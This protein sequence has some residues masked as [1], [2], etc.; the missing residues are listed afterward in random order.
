MIHF[1][2]DPKV[3]SALVRTRLSGPLLVLDKLK[4]ANAIECYFYWWQTV[5]I[6][7]DIVRIA[8]PS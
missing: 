8:N 1:A 3:I 4:K 5:K 2:D 7:P 6:L